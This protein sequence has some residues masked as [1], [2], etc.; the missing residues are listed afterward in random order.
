M[1]F[2]SNLTA[3]LNRYPQ[4]G[5]LIK[6]F[7]KD[8]LNT[9]NNQQTP[10]QPTS[11]LLDELIK[12]SRDE[13]VKNELKA[14]KNQWTAPEGQEGQFITLIKQ[15]LDLAYASKTDDRAGYDAYVQGLE[16]L[17]RSPYLQPAQ[18]PAQ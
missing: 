12:D 7:L 3:L 16:G 10:S 13:L 1:L 17:L 4:A 15:G 18:Q 8:Q 5:D 2:R 11:L 14:L 9:P 6:R